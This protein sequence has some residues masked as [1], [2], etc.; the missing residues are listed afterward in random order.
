MT[1]IHEGRGENR[2]NCPNLWRRD[3]TEGR[4]GAVP[5]VGR[6]KNRQKHPYLWQGFPSCAT[7]KGG[8]ARP[9][10]FGQNELIESLYLK[11]ANVDQELFVSAVVWRDSGRLVKKSNPV[12]S[13]IWSTLTAKPA[14]FSL[15]S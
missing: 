8:A 5:P 12:H 10:P 11:A 13:S 9:R 7:R 6:G 3:A 14:Y 15:L 2:Q 1:V 4:A